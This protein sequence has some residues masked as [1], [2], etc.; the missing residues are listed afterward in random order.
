MRRFYKRAEVAARADGYAVLLD[1]QPINTPAG[2]PLLAP[3]AGLAVALVEE[4]L[5]Q[6]ETIRL[7]RMPLTRLAG[8]A[9]DRVSRARGPV[10]DALMN[11]A[12]SDLLCHR[13]ESPRELAARQHA[14]WQPLLDWAA[15][16]LGAELAV[17]AG[18][19]PVAQPAAALAALRRVVTG[20]DD[21]RL[22]A[23][24][25]LVAG[26]GS[27]VLGLA[28]AAGRMTIEDAFAASQLDE[29]WQE[30]LWGE[31]EEAGR[32]RAHL[33]DELLA[34]A[35]LLELCLAEEAP[36]GRPQ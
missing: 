29:A 33:K 10:I 4:W 30:E 27:L 31:D 28:V 5:A 17:T 6:G 34:D 16:E 11:Y 21:L 2:Q 3:V 13:A 23:L 35:R 14:V 7:D 19:M 15:A 12:G 18:V 20:F 24:A 26:L 1:G 9:I 22:T 25:D 36:G 32:R 8:T